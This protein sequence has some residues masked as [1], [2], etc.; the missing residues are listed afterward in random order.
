ME[1]P[2]SDTT[3]FTLQVGPQYLFLDHHHPWIL[4]IKSAGW[5]AIG[6]LEV[7]RGA[8]WSC[9]EGSKEHVWFWW[10]SETQNISRTWS[11]GPSSHVQEE[12]C[13]PSRFGTWGGSNLWVPNLQIKATH[14]V[15][16]LLG[17]NRR[18]GLLWTISCCELPRSSGLATFGKKDSGLDGPQIRFSRSLLMFLR[19]YAVW[20]H[21]I[22]LFTACGSWLVEILPWDKPFK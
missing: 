21:D 14:C 5:G 18:V 10:T 17:E 1:L 19:F 12:L 16:F 6:P 11:E 9:L 22:I 4:I 20:P 7:T 15:H 3:F 8:F 2:G 13:G